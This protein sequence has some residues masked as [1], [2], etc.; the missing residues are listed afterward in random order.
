MR[1]LH[2]AKNVA[3][4]AGATVRALRRLGHEAELWEYDP[5]PFGYP[6]DRTILL[7]RERKDPATFWRTFLEALDRFDVFHFHFAR[8]LFPAEWGGLPAFWDLPLYRILGKRV[9]F[10]FHGSDVRIRRIHE[11]VNPWSYY[12]Y[13][14]I[15][16]DDERTEKIIEVCRAYADGLFVVSVDYRHFVPEAEV[17]P[18]VL[19]LA[20]WPEQAPDQ[21]QRPVVLHVPSRRGTKGTDLILAG[22]ERLREA[23]VEFDLRL[24]E[25]VPHAEARRAIQDADIVVDNLLTGDYEVVSIEAMASSRVAVANVGQDVREAFPDAP[26]VSA[27]PDDF[28]PVMRALILD[29]DRRRRLAAAGRPY[30]ERVHSADVVAARLVAAYERPPRPLDGATRSFPDWLS[31]APT[32][33]IERL[34]RE[35]ARTELELVRARY[36][37]ELLRRRLGLAPLG[38]VDARIRPSG[39]EILKGLLPEPVK[40]RLRRL[41]ARLANRR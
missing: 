2:A 5:N 16:A 36:R 1:I 27:T 12:K 40:R 37:E 30:V 8:T 3:D 19:D 35:L 25:G 32:R 10:T 15:P 21:R 17:M 20:D 18:R 33:R 11:Q 34:E 41:R 24:L 29:L 39:L 22:L 4:Q 31:M 6:A 23:G 9:F 13:S 28:E 14:D 38:P 26:V 7:D